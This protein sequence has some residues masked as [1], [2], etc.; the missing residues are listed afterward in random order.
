M[1]DE[2]QRQRI[3]VRHEPDTGFTF[4]VYPPGK[5]D[6]DDVDDLFVK[7]ERHYAAGETRFLLCDARNTGGFTPEA[8]QLM[9]QRRGNQ[10]TY[11]ANFGGSFA[12]RAF[13]NLLIKAFSLTHKELVI[14]MEADEAS[15]RAWL[16]EKRRTHGDVQA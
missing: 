15:A 8:R 5:L 14:T 6:V 13:S 9:A 3:Q 7:L 1:A 12:T 2:A 16:T 10:M 4:I 11:S